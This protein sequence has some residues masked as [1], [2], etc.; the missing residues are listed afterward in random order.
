M[1]MPLYKKMLSKNNDLVSVIVPVFNV[2]KY[3][4]N[5]INSILNQEYSNLEIIL[6][7]D[8]STDHS[9]KLCDS[10]LSVDS[11]IKVFHKKNGGL[12]D[13][14][15]YGIQ[16]ATGNYITFIDSDDIVS[17]KL[18]KHLMSLSQK[19]EADISI[20]NPLHIFNKKTN[21]YEFKKPQKIEVLDTKQSLNKMF[22]QKD[23]LVS[24][25][26]KLY[27]KQLFNNIKFPVGML[28]EDIAIM[29]K[30]FYNSN[31]VVYSDAKFYGYYHRENSITTK[32]FSVKDL[33]ILKICNDLL[34]FSNKHL[35]YKKSIRAYTINANLRIYLNAPRNDKYQF[36]INKCEKYISQNKKQVLKDKNIRKKLRMALILFTLNKTVL[37]KI[38]PKI[39]RWK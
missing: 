28:F 31:V 14:R 24:A 17:N 4:S 5:C 20:C 35:E 11:R 18:I 33:D 22:Y 23:F 32:D 13:A 39:N 1:N 29:Y 21:N 16:Y 26:G 30:L 9:G 10:F 8:G 7:D 12:S 19:Y 37:K 6:V 2:E 34:M 3:L 38:Y 15:N 36:Y 27:K 25:W